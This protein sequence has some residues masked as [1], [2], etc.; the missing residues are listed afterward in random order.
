VSEYSV[1]QATPARRVIRRPRKCRTLIGRF[2]AL[3]FR[4]FAG[5]LGEG[6]EERFER[7]A[8][9]TSRLYEE[10]RASA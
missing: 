7:I 8:L 10:I 4:Y 6:E 2:E 1:E 9:L 3:E 5:V